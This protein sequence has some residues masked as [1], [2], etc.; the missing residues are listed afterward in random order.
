MTGNVA[1][2]CPH[3]VVHLSTILSVPFKAQL[4]LLRKQCLLWVSFTTNVQ[5]VEPS[6]LC[7]RDST[8][9]LWSTRRLS[10]F[11]DAAVLD[12]VP[13][14]GL[15]AFW[16]LSIVRYS[17]GHNVSE[18][19]SVSVLRRGNLR[20]SLMLA[21]TK[22]PNRVDVS[23]LLIWRR[24]QIQLPKLACRFLPHSFLFTTH[25]YYFFLSNS[26]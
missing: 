2:R 26:A 16:S 17:K 25:S 1:E 19:R 12:I 23:Y 8:C 4:V 21:L 10:N 11:Q 20:L 9:S 13:H 14:P 22:G 24:K 6:G 18:T 7:N 5:Q 3:L 15:L